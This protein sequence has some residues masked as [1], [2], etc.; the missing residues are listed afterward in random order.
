M[1]EIAAK[2]Q[3]LHP[4]HHL[5]RLSTE[6]LAF[7]FLAEDM[8]A[9]RGLSAEILAVLEAPLKLGETTVDISLT[10]GLAAHTLHAD[11][12]PSLV[13]RA[14]IALDQARA[15]RR[16]IGVFDPDLYGDPSANLSLMSDMLH[17]IAAGELVLHHQPKLDLR[18]GI[19]T[20]VEA[21]V[22][23]RHPVRGL[24]A[25]D[26]FIPMAEETGHIGALTE[27]VLGRAIEEQA[28]L[29]HEGHDLSMS[30]NISGRLL[31]DADFAQ[32]AL[33]MAR[34]AR[35]DLIFEITETAV[36]ENPEVALQVIE[37]FAANGI[38]ISIDDYGTGLSSL[39]Y[40]KQIRADELKIDKAFV[41]KMDESQKDALLVRST[42]DLAHSLGLKVTA[43]GVETQ[44][45]LSLLT[46]MGCDIAQGFLIA[47]PIPLKELLIFLAHEKPREKRFG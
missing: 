40:L 26:L 18:T 3:G 23:W 10:V 28:L 11:L 20:G 38:S 13:E 16:K 47:R 21:L 9:A 41:F 37:T 15:A 8:E 31:G 44:V 5:A 39:A 35:G 4:E 17:G 19:V 45:A 42:I 6:V 46:G 25:P 14:N 12:V 36:I 22:R 2:L 24:L 32:M 30:V 27:W 7:A 33:E 1:R 43:E 29:S 34:C